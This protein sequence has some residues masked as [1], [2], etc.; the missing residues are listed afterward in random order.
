MKSK[1]KIKQDKILR[2]AQ[3]PV[4][5]Q[6]AANNAQYKSIECKSSGD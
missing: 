6:N 1:V 5:H 4:N 2:N 3:R